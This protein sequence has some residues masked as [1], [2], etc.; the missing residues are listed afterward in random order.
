VATEISGTETADVFYPRLNRKA[1]EVCNVA[2]GQGTDFF[3][4]ERGTQMYSVVKY[5]KNDAKTDQKS[6]QVS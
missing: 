3:H 1:F 5:A 6:V 4:P 2:Y